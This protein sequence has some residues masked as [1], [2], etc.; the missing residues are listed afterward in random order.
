[1]S[2][3]IAAILAYWGDGGWL[4][5]PIAAVL[6]GIWAYWFRLRAA[7]REAVAEARSVESRLDD[8]LAGRTDLQAWRASMEQ[9]AS[10]IDRLVLD[11]YRTSASGPEAR[12]LYH[13]QAALQWD[14]LK[15]DLF[16]LKALTAAAPLLGLLG[17]VSGM[18]DTFSAVSRHGAESVAL[19][20]RGISTA[21][22]TTQFGLVAALPGVFGV[23]NL[24]R[25]RTRLL[26][27]HNAIGGMLAAAFRN[28][29]P[30]G[31]A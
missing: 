25:L 31:A 23:I 2:R 30:K 10:W 24:G 29:G 14:R 1:M 17:T 27:A 7:L 4:L 5:M 12:R 9:N 20:A 8:W 13:V 6:F 15:R 26:S 18:V 3:A 21:L 16:V 19:V 11:V 28:G 22:V